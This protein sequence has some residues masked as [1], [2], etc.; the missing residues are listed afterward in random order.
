MS[1][2]TVA[3]GYGAGTVVGWLARSLIPWR[4]GL[5]ATA[6]WASIIPPPGWTAQRTAELG[7]L[8][9]N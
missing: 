4:P 8:P 2:I 9:A 5:Q 6:A 1:G 3:I 7:A